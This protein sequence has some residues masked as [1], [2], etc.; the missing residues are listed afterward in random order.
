MEVQLGALTHTNNGGRLFMITL[1]VRHGPQH[2]LA[3]LLDVERSALRSIR[4]SARWRHAKRNGLVG[5]VLAL[6]VTHGLDRPGGSWHPHFHMLLFIENGSELDVDDFAWI[7]TAWANRVEK[8][9]GTRP[10]SHGYHA[11]E[12][13]A[14]AAEYVAKVADETARADLKS[15]SRNVWHIIDAF[16]AGE[17][18]AVRAWHEYVVAMKG[19]S[20]VRW[21]RGLRD[22]L[23]LGADK[24]DEELAAEEVD[25]A[26]LESGDQRSLTRMMRST[27]RGVP[28][29][30]AKLELWEARLRN[31]PG[32]V[33][34]AEA[35][36]S[37]PALEPV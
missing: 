21:S 10:N 27:F 25:G 7:E 24:T 15:G 30:V 1:T 9:L 37:P 29:A 14:S 33:T 26:V 36:E 13:D 22:R 34:N 28:T 4:Q 35:A 23:G 5:D 6:E 3:Q 16:E 18:W 2:T 17:T 19:K 20:S 11:K 8:R 32:H 12:L 31:P